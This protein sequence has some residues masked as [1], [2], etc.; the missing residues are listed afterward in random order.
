MIRWDRHRARPAIRTRPGIF[1]PCFGVVVIP[2]DHH[3]WGF[4]LE[5]WVNHLRVRN[6]IETLHDLRVRE[7]G[8]YPFTQRIHPPNLLFGG[9]SRKKPSGSVV[10]RTNFPSEFSGQPSPEHPLL[11]HLGQLRWRCRRT[12]QRR[13]TSRLRLFRPFPPPTL[14]VSR[15]FVFPVSLLSRTSQSRVRAPSIR[16]RY[17]EYRSTRRPYLGMIIKEAKITVKNEYSAR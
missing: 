15:W 3:R 1:C 6:R 5:R 2:A 7:R 8:L 9:P 10:S 13:K 12:R 14:G 16:R 11:G 4:A 17:L